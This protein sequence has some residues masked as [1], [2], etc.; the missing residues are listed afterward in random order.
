MPSAR[1]DIR[2][3][4]RVVVCLGL[5]TPLLASP[6]RSA[7]LDQVWL[8]GFAHSINYLGDAKESGTADAQLEIDSTPP[9]LLRPIGSPRVNA[10]LSLNTAG[11]TD[12]ASLGLTWRRK[13]VGRLEGSLDAGLGFGDGVTNPP[14]GPL[15]DYDRTHRL[16]LGSKL[17]FRAAA[18]VD[19][20][21]D[22]RWSIGAEFVHL[23][24][25]HIF[26]RDHNEGIND[27][28]LRLGYRFR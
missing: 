24:N 16:L 13:L 14:P 5:A 19:W 25:G 10:T 18:G 17:L 23:S 15:G 3:A 7:I 8:G 22:S 12:F 4:A 11:L 21:I 2:S 9:A 27:A 6:A 20:R 28:G 1:S 26:N